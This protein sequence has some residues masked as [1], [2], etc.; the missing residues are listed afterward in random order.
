[1][2]GSVIRLARFTLAGNGD[3][4]ANPNDEL[5]GGVRQAATSKLAAA[6]V[7]E[8][9][10]ATPLLAKI[11]ASIATIEG[12]ANPG[13]NIDLASS[14]TITV[15]SGPLNT[16]TQTA[17]PTAIK[18]GDFVTFNKAFADSTIEVWMGSRALSG[19]LA[20]GAVFFQIRI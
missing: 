11:N 16:A 4:P 17:G 2:D 13:G 3:I 19:A 7:L 15:I 1:T 6:S 14:G 18:L 10:L 20:G 12:I 8:S 9:N 5:D